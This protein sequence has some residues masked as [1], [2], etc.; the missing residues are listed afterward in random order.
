M[1]SRTCV[2]IAIII[3][4]VFF[5]SSS[6]CSSETTISEK[7]LN[8]ALPGPLSVT[9][10]WALILFQIFISPIDNRQCIFSPT[11]S[12]YARQVIKKYG[13]V[14]AYPLITARLIRCNESAYFSIKYEM[15]EEGKGGFCYDPLP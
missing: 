1:K 4:L 15:A 5:Q 12:V 13:F 14:A 3:A 7:Y 10:D 8:Q 9:S 11:C 6:V 2:M